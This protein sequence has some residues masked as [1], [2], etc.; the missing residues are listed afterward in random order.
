MSAVIFMDLFI[1]LFLQFKLCITVFNTT[2][3]WY[4]FNTDDMLKGKKIS[5]NESPGYDTGVYFWSSIKLT[6][7]KGI[8]RQVTLQC[9]TCRSPFN[10]AALLS[11]LF[12]SGLFM[13]SHEP[14]RLLRRTS[15]AI[16]LEFLLAPPRLQ[17]FVIATLCA[18]VLAR[19]KWAFVGVTLTWNWANP[20]SGGGIC[21]NTDGKKTMW[22]SP[23]LSLAR[24]LKSSSLLQGGA[25][26]SICLWC[27][28]IQPHTHTHG[29]LPTLARRFM[30]KRLSFS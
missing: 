16:Q 22:S 27:V 21:Q 6:N 28:Q 19:T 10:L 7:W 5:C 3:T 17:R 1:Y 8:F 25:C 9:I 13:R 20:G 11:V 15:C 2:Y 4:V 26:K 30:A 18:L 24:P 12:C 14:L 23:A 29:T